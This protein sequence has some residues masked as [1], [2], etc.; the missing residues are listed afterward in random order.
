MVV[1][2]VDFTAAAS[3][4]STSS[5]ALAQ[6]ADRNNTNNNSNNHN[7]NRLNPLGSMLRRYIWDQCHDALANP[8]ISSIVLTGGSN[9]NFSAGADLTEFTSFHSNNDDTNSHSHSNSYT[10]S[11]LDLIQ[12]LD[13]SRKP[14]VA[15]IEGVCLGGGLEL[16]L[17]CHYRVGC[18][19]RSTSTTSSRSSSCKLG[20]P[21][22]HVGVIPGA[23]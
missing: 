14:I 12:V 23:G 6:A 1:H 19:S 8:N 18:A 16:A 2:V 17:A 3:S 11:L 15:C 10:P 4:S 7:N 20:L 21:E 22:V 9:R 13:T 5:A